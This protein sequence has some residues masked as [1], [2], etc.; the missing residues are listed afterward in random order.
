MQREVVHT[1]YAQDTHAGES[2]ADTIHERAARITKVVGHGVTLAR[3]LDENGFRLTPGF[4]VLLAAQVLQVRV[5]DG[6]VC[7]VY[8]RGE[9][10]AVGAVADERASESRAMG[11]LEV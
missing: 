11:W 8:G 3:L 1:A 9:F 10:M 7:C 6:E 4:E 5:V 2:R